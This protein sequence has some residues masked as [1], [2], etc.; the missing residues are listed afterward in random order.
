VET[1][2]QARSPRPWPQFEARSSTWAVSL[3][4]VKKR[5]EKLFKKANNNQKEIFSTLNKLLVFLTQDPLYKPYLLNDIRNLAGLLFVTRNFGQKE[6]AKCK[7]ILKQVLKK[8]REIDQK[9]V[10]VPERH[11]L[12]G[13]Q[14]GLSM[15]KAG[16]MST[17]PPNSNPLP[18]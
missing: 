1:L 10:V 7:Q 13:A 8:A 15:Q 18:T 3:N 17:D 4:S 14:K 9:L 11:Q 5:L 16:P 12:I 2:N 6:L